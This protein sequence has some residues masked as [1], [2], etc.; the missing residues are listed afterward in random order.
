MGEQ[1]SVDVVGGSDRFGR[2]TNPLGKG[3]LP[4]PIAKL[5]GQIHGKWFMDV[6]ADS[7]L[8]LLRHDTTYESVTENGTPIPFIKPRV[9]EIHSQISKQR[10]MNCTGPMVSMIYGMPSWMPGGCTCAGSRWRARHPIS[11]PRGGI[12]KNGIHGQDQAP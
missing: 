8:W 1:F 3:G 9:S 2:T 11:C 10:S 5:Y 7:D 4:G 6:K 12:G